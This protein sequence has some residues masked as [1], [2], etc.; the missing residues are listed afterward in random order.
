MPLAACEYAFR[1]ENPVMKKMISDFTAQG[2][3]ISELEKAY[4][5]VLEEHYPRGVFADTVLGWRRK[6]D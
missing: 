3:S 2:G 1:G 4:K 6:P 5:E